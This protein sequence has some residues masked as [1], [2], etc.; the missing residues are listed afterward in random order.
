MNHTCALAVIST[1]LPSKFADD[2]VDNCIFFTWRSVL[3]KYMFGETWRCAF[4]SVK[5]LSTKDYRMLI[6]ILLKSDYFRGLMP[7]CIFNL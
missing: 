2:I 1:G 5:S 4:V 7:D 3:R 6:E